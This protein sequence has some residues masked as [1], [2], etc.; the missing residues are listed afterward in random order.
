MSKANISYDSLIVLLIAAQTRLDKDPVCYCDEDGYTCF[1]C[2]L[3]SAMKDVIDKADLTVRIP[4][5]KKNFA[6][7]KAESVK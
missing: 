1:H 2:S 3:V 6:I 7:A 5:I 4:E